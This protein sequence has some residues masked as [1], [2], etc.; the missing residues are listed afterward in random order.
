MLIVSASQ[1]ALDIACKVFLDPGDCV[2]AGAPP[3]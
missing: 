3:T 1:Q 2:I